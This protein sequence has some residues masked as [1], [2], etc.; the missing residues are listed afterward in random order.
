VRQ[1]GVAGFPA[2]TQAETPTAKHSAAKS[3]KGRSD[4]G[5]K[6]CNTLTPDL[7]IAARWGYA[8]QGGVTKPGPGQITP[9]PEAR[10]AS[11]STSTPPPAGKTCRSKCGTTPSAA[12]KSSRSGS[13]TASPPC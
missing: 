13:A 8:G 11:T 10:A 12:T 2:C 3:A 7:A 9:A 1:Q 4:A 6:A 5:S